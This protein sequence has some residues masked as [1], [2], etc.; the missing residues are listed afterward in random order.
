MATAGVPSVAGLA[1][2]DILR[3]IEYAS[4]SSGFRELLKLVQTEKDH[5]SSYSRSLS[6]GYLLVPLAPVITC[7]SSAVRLAAH[8]T[9]VQV[10]SS[11]SYPSM[12][13][14]HPRILTWDHRVLHIPSDIA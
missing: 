11:S 10:S 6:S 14:S 9:V 5:T 8:T 3:G 4:G 13:A 12:K 2:I 7:V 1:Q